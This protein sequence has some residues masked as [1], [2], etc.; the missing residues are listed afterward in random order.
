MLTGGEDVNPATY[1][2][3]AGRFTYFTDRDAYEIKAFNAAQKKGIPTIGICRGAQIL[4]AFAGGSLVQHVT[5]HVGRH[6]IITDEGKTLVM[7]SL[8][9]QMMRPEN[10]EH[11][12]IAWTPKA[13]SDCYLDGRDMEIYPKGLDK[14]PEIVYFPKIK[15]LAIQ[16]H[17]EM[18]PED[19]PTVAYCNE[20][21]RQYLL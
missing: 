20:L 21:V 19:H 17:P 6:P 8:H 1:G 13:L 9:H 16:G 3:P 14:E 2:E 7:S 11:K 15:G 18:L 12:L 4:C 10:T 5:G